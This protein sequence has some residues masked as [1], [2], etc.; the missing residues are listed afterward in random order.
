[1]W[2]M[3]LKNQN[4]AEDYVGGGDKTRKKMRAPNHR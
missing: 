4:A 1:M 3:Q 2:N